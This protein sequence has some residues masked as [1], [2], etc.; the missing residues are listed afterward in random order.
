MNIIYQKLTKENFY[1]TSLDDFQRYQEVS[2]CWRKID[3]DYKLS[4]V[5]YIEDWELS[6]LRKMAEKILQGL[7]QGCVGY[8][9]IINNKI[10]GF[11]YLENL[12]FGDKKQYINLGE[13]YVS[14]PFRRRGIG[15]KL[16]DMTCQEAKELG[17]SKLYISAHSA[18]E[19]ICAYKSYG[20]TFAQEVNATLAQKEP[21][22]LQLEFS[23][24]LQIYQVENKQDF[25]D[26]LLLG[27]EQESMIRKY[28]E[29][30]EM[31]VIDDDGIK[32]EIVVCSV[33]GGVL[34][35]KNLAILPEFQKMG[36]GRRLIEFILKK[37]NTKFTTIQVGT[38]DSHLTIP[39][40]EKCGFVKSHIV[41]NFFIEN[42]DHPIVEDGK[43]LTDMI[44]LK[45]ILDN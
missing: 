30:G 9:A 24:N 34:E 42:Y 19:S 29:K 17:A 10:V 23:L 2:K 6:E 18:E 5:H 36:Y 31:F 35:I 44:Y 14:F 41:K 12:F 32:G 28:L 15:K 43:Q 8:A 33:G 1:L 3:G 38:G 13:L 4:D 37:Y 7:S 26:L 27:D 16:F 45:R 25:M 11:A 20:C 22:D 39:F 21:F 40:Y